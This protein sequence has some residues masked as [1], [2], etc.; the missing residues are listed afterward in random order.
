MVI[1]AAGVEDGRRNCTRA[2]LQRQKSGG[3][4]RRGSDG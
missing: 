4:S 3:T 2:G 1:S